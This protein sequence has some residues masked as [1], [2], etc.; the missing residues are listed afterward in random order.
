MPS[1]EEL[2]RHEVHAE[3]MGRYTN[4]STGFHPPCRAGFRNG[5]VRRDDRVIPAML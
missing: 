2:R 5:F 1:C 3:S 4:T